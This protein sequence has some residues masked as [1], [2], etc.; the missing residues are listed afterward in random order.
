MLSEQI[1]V[2]KRKSSL[3]MF[4]LNKKIALM[5]SLFSSILSSS[6]QTFLIL[7]C[8]SFEIHIPFLIQTYSIVNFK[9]SPYCINN[10]KNLIQHLRNLIKITF[11]R[12]KS[13]W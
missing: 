9:T 7:F 13:K 12:L 8:A 11:I 10:L 2:L 4:I 5:S 3:K 6:F 1:F